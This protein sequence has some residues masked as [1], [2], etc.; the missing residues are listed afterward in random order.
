MMDYTTPAIMHHRAIEKQI[1]AS[2]SANANDESA[3]GNEALAKARHIEAAKSSVLNQALSTLPQR[4][5]PSQVNMIC[6]SLLS[7]P[8]FKMQPTPLQPDIAAHLVLLDVPAGEIAISEVG[9][10]VK[11]ACGSCSPTSLLKLP[12]LTL[13]QNAEVCDDVYLIWS[14]RFSLSR[15]SSK[16]AVGEEGVEGAIQ[17]TRQQKIVRSGDCFG[18]LA[19]VSPAFKRITGT[20]GVSLFD[21]QFLQSSTGQLPLCVWPVTAI[22]LE[23]SQVLCHSI[24][25]CVKSLKVR[26]N[27]F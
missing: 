14:G 10:Q 17:S 25:N 7:N 20:V 21:K 5:T 19:H 23:Q 2:S 26:P 3:A 16:Q 11:R 22:A 27:R 15:G 18:N 6:N 1:L 9:T 24:L 12:S 13:M 8:F 4:R